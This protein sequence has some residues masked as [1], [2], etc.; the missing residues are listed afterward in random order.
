MSHLLRLLVAVLLA[1]FLAG[2][3]SLATFNPLGSMF[4]RHPLRVGVAP[5]SPPLIMKKNGQTNG[6]EV[7]FAQGLAQSLDRRLE[8]VELQRDELADALLKKRIDIIMSGISVAE[9][10]RHKLA[11]STP[12]LIS[13]Q[14]VLVHLDDFQ[15]FGRG[16]RALNNADV[17]LGV[18]AGSPGETLVQDLK[19]K[20][21]I[22]RYPSGLAGLRALLMDKVDLFIY[23]FPAN[24]LYAAKFVEQG[25]TPGVTLLTREPL[26]WAILP[27]N[28]DLQHQANTYLEGISRSGELEKMLTRAI[29]F[30]R[31][32]A[33]SP[34]P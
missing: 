26:A 31:N 1:C 22:S 2:C 30:Y 19:A 14:V 27:E 28:K 9:V 18:V 17:R 7:E 34:K 10:Q 21:S 16:T 15:Q 4:G 11:H 32:T 24:H 8:L 12:Y 6:L 23:D 33:Y 13:G 20:G 5:D 3:G 29:P 25:L